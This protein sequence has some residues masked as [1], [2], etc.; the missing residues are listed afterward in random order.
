EQP[1]PGNGT[2]GQLSPAMESLTHVIGRAVAVSPGERFESAAEMAGQLSGVLRDFMTL[3]TARPWPAPVSRFG[4]ETELPDDSLGTV[5]ELAWWLT[6]DAFR[7][8]GDGGRLLPLPAVPDAAAARLP[9]PRPDPGDPAAELVLTLSGTKAAAAIEQLAGQDSAEAD[10]L[11]CR[12]VL[13]LGDIAGARD[14][15][16]RAADRCGQGDWRVRWH[17]ALTGMAAGRHQEAFAEFSAVHRALP[18]ELVPKLGLALCA[19]CLGDARQEAERWYALAWQADQ[20]YV[21]AAFGL[22]RARIRSGDRG[23]AVTA[24]DG[25]QGSSRHART[26]RIAAFRLLTCVTGEPAGE[27]DGRPGDPSD[28][29]LDQAGRRLAAPPLSDRDTDLGEAHYLLDAVLLEARLHR[30]CAP[31]RGGSG[32]AV[33]KLRGDLEA[34]YRRMAAKQART[35]GQHTVLVDLANQVRARSLD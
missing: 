21:S 3:R 4:P 33:A 28:E 17:K 22:A 29:E 35:R 26:A 11:R 19:E 20:S 27:T 6:Q 13:S 34:S 16:R 23:A 7:A 1:G 32:G 12:A 10:L 30:A 9:A 15:L 24:V 18:G 5:P 8:A 25:V 14:A 31:G 2:G